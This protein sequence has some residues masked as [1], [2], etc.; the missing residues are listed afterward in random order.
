MMLF[1]PDLSK[2]C[3]MEVYRVEKS[4]QN[5]PMVK[6][7][8]LTYLAKEGGAVGLPENKLKVANICKMH[9]TGGVEVVVLC[10]F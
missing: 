7:F 6:P 8:R 1:I 9:G 4:N 10:A 5:P 3:G 2:S